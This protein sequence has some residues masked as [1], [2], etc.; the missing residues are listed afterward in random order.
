MRKSTVAEIAEFINS[1]GFD[2]VSEFTSE[3]TSEGTRILYRKEPKLYFEIEEHPSSDFVFRFFYTRFDK[4]YPK[5]GSHPQHQPLKTMLLEMKNWLIGHIKVYKQDQ[6]IL[7]PWETYSFIPTYELMSGDSIN[8]ISFE[9]NDSFTPDEQ[10]VIKEVLDEAKTYIQHQ[11]S[12][13]DKSVKL[14]LEKID[15]VIENIQKQGKKDW[16]Q[17]A[18]EVFSNL[19]I[20]MATDIENFQKIGGLFTYIISL[21]FPQVGPLPQIGN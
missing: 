6:E 17:Y 20:S 21:T 4:L 16:K 18:W 13:E 9:T 7:N 3:S 19:A 11:L 15:I 5:S 14:I 10:K 2:A 8:S 12:L 1:Q